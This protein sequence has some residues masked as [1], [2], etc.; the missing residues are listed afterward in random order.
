MSR[1]YRSRSGGLFR[2]TA[3]LLLLALLATS[4][5]ASEVHFEE[6][7]DDWDLTTPGGGIMRVPRGYKQVKPPLNP[8]RVAPK[9]GSFDNAVQ[10]LQLYK[11]SLGADTGSAMNALNALNVVLYDVQDVV[12]SDDAL[13]LTLNNIR[14]FA[15]AVLLHSET[16]PIKAFY[17]FNVASSSHN[18]NPATALLPLHLPN[19]VAVDWGATHSAFDTHLRSLKLLDESGALEDAASVFCT[20][21]S[22]RPLLHVR[23]AEWLADFRGLL[24]GYDSCVGL[25]GAE[26]RCDGVPVALTHAFMLRPDLVRSLVDGMAWV[27][28]KS[29]GR[30]VPT[31]DHLMKELSA[32]VRKQGFQVASMLH[33]VRYGQ[34]SPS[35]C[36]A[37]WLGPYDKKEKDKK[38]KAEVCASQPEEVLLLHWSGASLG[39]EGF[40]CSKSLGMSALKG[41]VQ[42]L[43]L[44][45]GQSLSS[46]NSSSTGTEAGMGTWAHGALR[47]VLPEQLVGGAL[48]ILFA[49]YELERAR[50]TTALARSSPS[51]LQRA[52]E[53]S[54]QDQAQTPQIPQA[55]A[56][57]ARVLDVAPYS[58]PADSSVCFLVRTS[59]MHDPQY[60]HKP[61]MQKYLHMDLDVIVQCKWEGL[62]H[63]SVWN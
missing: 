61:P 48:S 56:A 22:V 6:F 60:V 12:D 43:T 11:K 17:L 33:H 14:V 53:T 38:G 8:P 29:Q 49:E 20:G 1:L 5:C 28:P 41:R 30:L 13:Q 27:T 59:K 10:K 50:L 35:D 45:L 7:D 21:S 2:L 37:A 51:P 23:D 34:A 15:T 52:R 32:L 24:G 31:A 39:T 54:E 62:I 55:R 57:R 47:P 16:A 18:P 46:F 63:I 25:V 58:A 42:E 36:S 9:R 19:V 4:T 40:M 3:G 44:A 26:A